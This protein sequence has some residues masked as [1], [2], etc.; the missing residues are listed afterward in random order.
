MTV[1]PDHAA[2]L[3]SPASSVTLCRPSRAT[4]PQVVCPRCLRPSTVAASAGRRKG[5]PMN[6][7]A[8]RCEWCGDVIGVYEPLV[9]VA[10]RGSRTTSIAAEP[11]LSHHHGE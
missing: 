1:K 7:Y 5:A 4:H 3:H 2:V 6:H 11:H 8:V 10:H 9:V